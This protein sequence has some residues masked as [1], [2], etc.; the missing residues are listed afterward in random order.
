MKIFAKIKKFT[1]KIIPL[2]N[3]DEENWQKLHDDNEYK[4]EITTPRNYMFH[5]KYMALINLV[6]KNQ[7]KYK[8]IDAMRYAI[9]MAAGYYKEVIMLSGTTLYFPVSISFAEMDQEKF[10]QLYSDV[11]DVILQKVLRGITK[12]DIEL[13]IQSFM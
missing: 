8:E 3:S 9:Q 5:K 6:F 7:D 10:E 1:H 4:I 2:Y 12:E 13:E 11:L